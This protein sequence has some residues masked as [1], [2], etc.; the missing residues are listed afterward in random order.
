MCGKIYWTLGTTRGYVHN[1][2]TTTGSVNVQNV[3]P[4]IRWNEFKNKEKHERTE[5]SKEDNS[6]KS[7]KF[8]CLE[9]AV[10]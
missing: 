5:S 9:V 8:I 2:Y 6:Q 1:T 10:L 3:K 7:S 4:C